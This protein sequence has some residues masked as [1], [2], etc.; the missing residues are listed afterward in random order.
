MGLVSAIL[1]FPVLF[2]V[3]A[4][5]RE[6]WLVLLISL[7][8]HAAYKVSLALAYKGSE[9]SK[10][11][12]LARGLIPF[13]ATPLSYI[14]LQQLPKPMQLAGIVVT[15]CGGIGLAI[16][17]RRSSFHIRTLFAAAAASL[18]VAGYS[19][20]DALGTR[21]ASG[22]LSFT[23][24]LIVLD[25][26]GFFAVARSIRGP[27]IWVE[28]RSALWTMLAAGALGVASFAVLLWALSRSPV[29]SVI[30]FR[31][32]GI[33]FTTLIGVLLLKEHVS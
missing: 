30:A 14:F 19:V 1:A 20:V 12:P 5:S 27:L 4:P 6:V 13:F 2:L 10:M 21:G 17:T 16:E 29:A 33:L 31:E 23:A 25:S 9:L 26:L 32:C 22:W 18:M 15:V 11:Y 7:F 28:V 3:P 8:L 24:W